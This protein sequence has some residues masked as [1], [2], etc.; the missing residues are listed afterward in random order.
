MLVEEHAARPG[1]VCR[2]LDL[3]PSSYYY[4]AQVKQE[5]DLKEAIQSV[6]GLFPTYGTRRITHQL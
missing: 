1:M 2:I 3:P 4:H 6:A 5:N